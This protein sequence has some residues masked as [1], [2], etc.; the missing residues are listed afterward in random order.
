MEKQR[1]EAPQL[2]VTEEEK[3]LEIEK[4]INKRKIYR[5]DKYLV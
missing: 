2:V 4:I 3:E 5:R 1:K